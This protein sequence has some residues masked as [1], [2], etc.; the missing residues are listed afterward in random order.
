MSTGDARQRTTPTLMGSPVKCRT[1]NA[2]TVLR[3][4]SHWRIACF[5]YRQACGSSQV[6]DV[7]STERDTS[8]SLWRVRRR[9]SSQALALRSRTVHKCVGNRVGRVDT[10]APMTT[11]ARRGSANSRIRTQPR[12]IAE[13]GR[14]Y[15]GP[16]E[17]ELVA[18]FAKIALSANSATLITHTLYL[19]S[20]CS[21]NNLGH[22]PDATHFGPLR[23]D[24]IKGNQ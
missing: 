4:E 5:V 22:W 17:Y 13:M 19:L 8:R 24:G 10:R 20:I 15:R 14:L 16:A 18:Q 1:G 11:P 3:D 9:K 12:R 23:R 2:A 6:E 21:R 7:V